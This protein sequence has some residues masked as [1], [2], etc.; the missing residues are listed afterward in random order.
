MKKGDENEGS[1]EKNAEVYT[2]TM[3][4]ITLFMICF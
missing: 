4:V 3:R 1:S 2:Q